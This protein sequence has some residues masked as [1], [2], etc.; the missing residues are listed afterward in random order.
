MREAYRGTK[1]RPGIKEAST[2]C[3]VWTDHN[4]GLYAEK[5]WSTHE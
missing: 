4:E 5:R 1:E 3:Q 2:V